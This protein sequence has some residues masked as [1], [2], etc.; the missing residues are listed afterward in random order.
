MCLG[1]Q[2]FDLIAILSFFRQYIYNG[3]KNKKLI[4]AINRFFLILDYTFKGIIMHFDN[5]KP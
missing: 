5:T 3:Y 1:M 2:Y 4:F